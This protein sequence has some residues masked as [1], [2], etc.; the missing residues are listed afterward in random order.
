MRSEKE[1]EMIIKKNSLVLVILLF[2][3]RNVVKIE[4]YCD[5]ETNYIKEH[6]RNGCL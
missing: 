5:T 3:A 2:N 6:S 4:L 1:V